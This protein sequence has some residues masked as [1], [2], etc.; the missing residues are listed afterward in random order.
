MTAYVRGETVYLNLPNGVARSKLTNAWFDSTLG[1]VC[2]MRNWA[3]IAR[4]GRL[5]ETRAS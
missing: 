2:T 4:L 1:V 3:T 5:L